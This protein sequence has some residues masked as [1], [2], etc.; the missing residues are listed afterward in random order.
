MKTFSLL[1]RQGL[2]FSFCALLAGTMLTARAQ[3]LIFAGGIHIGGVEGILLNGKNGKKISDV[4][5]GD[6]S[7]AL[8]LAASWSPC[9]THLAVGGQGAIDAD[10]TN[11][12]LRVYELSGNSLVK[13]A[14]LD[15]L[16]VAQHVAWSPDGSHLAY[17]QTNRLQVLSFDGASLTPASGIVEISGSFSALAWSPNGTDIAVSAPNFSATIQIYQFD[18]SSLTQSLVHSVNSALYNFT[19]SPDGAYLATAGPSGVA[20]GVYIFSYNG[21]SLTQV[22]TYSNGNR[23]DDLSWS[24][25][26]NYL[27]VA[28]DPAVSAN[29][30]HVFEFDTATNALVSVADYA[31]GT[32][33]SSLDWY[34]DN[35]TFALTDD[36]G[37]RVFQ[38][39]VNNGTIREKFAFD[40]PALFVVAV[41]KSC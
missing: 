28:E 16:P 22:A 4:Q 27:A 6:A 17:I 19:W 41:Q 30:V 34:D 35:K 11:S 29:N 3:D 13:V 1:S 39:N 25:N 31:S 8:V 32:N 9:G 37:V 18:G 20:A 15:N 24:K 26:G 33:T 10:G 7:G 2:A 40:R 38:A 14:A 21:T 36:Q 23:A 5:F 12:G